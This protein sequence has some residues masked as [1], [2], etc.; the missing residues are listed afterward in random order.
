MYADRQRER[1][2]ERGGRVSVFFFGGAGVVVCIY[3]G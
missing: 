3:V 2:S 1:E